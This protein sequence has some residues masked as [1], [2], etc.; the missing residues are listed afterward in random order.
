MKTLRVLAL[1]TLLGLTT[2]AFAD[3]GT[4][5]RTKST[6]ALPVAA[7]TDAAPATEQPAVAG[8]SVSSETALNAA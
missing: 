4:A 5:A 2:S 6:N 3:D 1:A 7:K 8:G